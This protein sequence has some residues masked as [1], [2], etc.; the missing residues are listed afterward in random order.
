MKKLIAISTTLAFALGVIGVATSADAKA[1]A[2]SAGAWNA[3]KYAACSKKT[4]DSRATSP[5][6]VFLADSCYYGQ[7]W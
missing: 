3:A 7:S 5:A 4:F 6:Q 1:R 2:R